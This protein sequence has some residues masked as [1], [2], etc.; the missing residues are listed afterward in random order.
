MLM[1]FQTINQDENERS[2][3]NLE[4]DLEMADQNF[5]NNPEMGIV[6]VISLE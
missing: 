5:E 1:K 3:P 2:S 4:G 6:L